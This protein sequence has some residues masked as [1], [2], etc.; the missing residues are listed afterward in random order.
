M[1]RI[2]TDPTAVATRIFYGN[3]GVEVTEFYKGPDGA[4]FSRKF[5]AWFNDPVTFEVGATGTFSGY[6]SVKIEDW[7][8]EDGTPK[9]DREGKPGRSANVSI[10][11]ATFESA[12]GHP[13]VVV[14]AQAPI[15][16]TPF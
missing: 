13:M 3:K 12:N 15:D 7:K 10:N 8:N 6:H 4:N 16:E 9:L 1:A 14:E 2:T 5:T 11:S